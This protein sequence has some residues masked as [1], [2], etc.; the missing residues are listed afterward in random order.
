M[1]ILGGLAGWGM[2]KLENRQP[3]KNPE[4]ERLFR[5]ILLLG[6]QNVACQYL[7]FF[8]RSLPLGE[9]YTI[10]ESEGLP[11]IEESNLERLPVFS[12]LCSY[13]KIMMDMEDRFYEQ[14]V[15][16]EH[17]FCMRKKQSQPEE[18]HITVTICDGIENAYIALRRY[19]SDNKAE[20]NN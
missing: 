6:K 18:Y 1:V 10:R 7:Y 12:E 5:Q 2:A 20:S 4:S 13:L 9:N 8:L 14:P 19:N 16:V 11:E 15:E 3:G 17:I